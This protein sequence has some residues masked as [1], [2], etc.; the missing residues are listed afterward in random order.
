MLKEDLATKIVSV[1]LHDCD[2]FI[3]DEEDAKIA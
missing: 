1:E 3:A 2:E